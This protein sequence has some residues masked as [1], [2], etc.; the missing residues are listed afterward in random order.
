METSHINSARSNNS[1]LTSNGANGSSY[2]TAK[3]EMEIINV[4]NANYIPSK[5]SNHSLRPDS[6]R[7]KLLQDL[8]H[9]NLTNMINDSP[10][11][12]MEMNKRQAEVKIPRSYNV[13]RIKKPKT[14]FKQNF[15]LNRN[16]LII[17]SFSYRFSFETIYIV[18]RLNRHARRNINKNL[19]NK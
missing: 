17:R 3:T 12:A 11:H 10:E 2:G 9:T 4:N 6:A 13:F 1:S 15:L 7:Y 5:H 16:M 18:F 19:C 14:V 8:R